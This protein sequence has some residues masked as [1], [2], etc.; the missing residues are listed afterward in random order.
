MIEK[1]WRENVRRT[2]AL[3]AEL[4][5]GWASLGGG[6]LALVCPQYMPAILGIPLGL[7]QIVLSGQAANLQRGYV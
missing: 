4:L 6:L 2:S 7:V 5:L 1:Q 3:L